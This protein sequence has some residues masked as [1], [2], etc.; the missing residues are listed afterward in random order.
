MLSTYRI[1]PS[2]THAGKE[3]LQTILNLTSKLRMTTNDLKVTSNDKVFSEN[4]K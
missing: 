2:N 1:P 3:R 4:K